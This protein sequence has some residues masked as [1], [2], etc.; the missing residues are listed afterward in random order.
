MPGRTTPLVEGEIYHVFNRG[1]D[2]RPTFLSKRDYNR[3]Y[4]TLAFY[5]FVHPPLRL[6][7]FLKFG[8]EKKELFIQKLHQHKKHV[9][10]LVYCLMPNH[11]HLCLRQLEP[12]GISKF[13]SNFQNSYTR[14][15]NTK[16]RRIG[17]LFLDQFKAVRIETDEQLLHISRYIHLNPFT[18]YVVKTLS[19][20]Q[21]YT[22]SSYGE[23]LQMKN[24]FCDT[25]TILSHFKNHQSYN[26][27]VFDQ[28][29]YQRELD[30]IK[31]LTLEN[32]L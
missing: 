31:H 24:G 27:F 1:L 29:N 26:K 16:T 32:S 28:A 8:Q 2:R 10:I 11:F 9:D 6:A 18:S 4:E 20:L 7:Y 30:A 23:Y 17:S 22:L 25:Q 3:A 21:K 14:Y 15:F 12:Y 19:D 13:L 5:R